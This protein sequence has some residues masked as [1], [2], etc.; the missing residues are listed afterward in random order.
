M[1][2]ITAKLLSLLFQESKIN[3]C[4]V[5]KICQLSDRAIVKYKKKFLGAVP[6]HGILCLK[7]E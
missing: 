2:C 6:E 7:S 1:L 4:E 5:G 3:G